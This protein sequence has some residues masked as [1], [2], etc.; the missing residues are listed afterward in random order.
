MYNKDRSVSAYLV[1]NYL[2]IK[3]EGD[4]MA[5]F[6]IVRIAEGEKAWSW[7]YEGGLPLKIKKE[8]YT[9][10][11]M[12]SIIKTL[13]QE[14]D[15]E[16][17]KKEGIVTFYEGDGG[18]KQQLAWWKMGND[19]IEKI[20]NEMHNAEMIWQNPEDDPKNKGDDNMQRNVGTGESGS[21]L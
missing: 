19:P 4:V 15:Y 1:Q 12:V 8:P 14:P 21:L 13:Q 6:V 20:I 7:K 17:D 18:D 5:K 3:K 9:E 11:E 16:V 2:P 10:M